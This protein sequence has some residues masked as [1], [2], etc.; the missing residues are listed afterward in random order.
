MKRG[1]K[2]TEI[3]A[4]VQNFIDASLPDEKFGQFL[5]VL[6]P[7]IVKSRRVMLDDVAKRLREIDPSLV[8]NGAIRDFVRKMNASREIQR[9]K[10]KPAKINQ[11]LDIVTSRTL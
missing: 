11:F 10:I 5:S 1:Q 6:S 4:I 2:K 7:A 8:S 9:S 3:P